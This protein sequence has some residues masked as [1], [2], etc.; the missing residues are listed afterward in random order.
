M[1]VERQRQA[2]AHDLDAQ[3]EAQSI[4]QLVGGGDP[5]AQRAHRQQ[6][7]GLEIGA[8]CSA[9]GQPPATMR[10]DANLVARVGWGTPQADPQLAAAQQ[11]ELHCD[12][13]VFARAHRQRITLHAIT[14][15]QQAAKFWM[16]HLTDLFGVE[17]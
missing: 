13:Y 10:T 2:C 6:H 7:R 16:V 17:R 9:D 15:Q 8:F 3:S 12:P 5:R 11:I 1:V 14:T 4:L